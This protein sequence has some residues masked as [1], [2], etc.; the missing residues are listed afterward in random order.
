MHIGLCPLEYHNLSAI[1]FQ[2]I[3]LDM[4]HLFFEKYLGND[5][6]KEN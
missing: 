4:I 3:K 5:T 2:W 1:L 6:I